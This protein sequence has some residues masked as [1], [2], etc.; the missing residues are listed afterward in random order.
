MFNITLQLEVL[1]D[2]WSPRRFSLTRDT[3][4]SYL[5][6]ISPQEIHF[7]FRSAIFPHFPSKYSKFDL[8]QV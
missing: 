4:L 3:M 8:E 6:L 7:L 5:S 1:C 2:I